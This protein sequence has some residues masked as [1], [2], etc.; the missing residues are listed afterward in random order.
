MKH[1]FVV[2][3]DPV[4]KGRPRFT[5][6]GRAYTPKR[7]KEYEARVRQ[8]YIDSCG[9]YFGDEEVSIIIAAYFE[10]PKS[11][12]KKKRRALEGKYCTKKPDTDNLIK[13]VLD[14][15]LGAAYEDDKQVVVCIGMKRWAEE[16]YM[17]V[18]ILG[19]HDGSEVVI[20]G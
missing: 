10:M 5:K 16:G 19:A 2:E 11:W 1:E 12:P 4:G 7:T 9:P 13:G 20:N 17:H 3:G 8:A 6:T 18:D 14:A 15:L